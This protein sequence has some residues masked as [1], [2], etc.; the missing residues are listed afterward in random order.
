[1]EKV[2]DLCDGGAG[3]FG[4]MNKTELVFLEL[5]IVVVEAYFLVVEI[6]PAIFYL[7]GLVGDKYSAYW[8][9]LIRMLF[10]QSLRSSPSF[11][12]VA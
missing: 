6:F 3:S 9:L 1:L 10:I 7:H 2:K 11:F 12:C 5:I 4:Q 8:L